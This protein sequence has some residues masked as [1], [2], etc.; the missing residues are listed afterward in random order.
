[1]P[2]SERSVSAYLC[3]DRNVYL[4]FDVRFRSRVKPDDSPSCALQ[5]GA[6]ADS[7]WLT[8]ALSRASAASRL[9]GSPCEAMP[10]V[11]ACDGGPDGWSPPR[12]I[13]GRDPLSAPV[14]ANATPRS[15]LRYPA[16]P[17]PPDSRPGREILRLTDRCRGGGIWSMGSASAQRAGARCA[18][19]MLSLRRSL[20]GEQGGWLSVS[21]G[22]VAWSPVVRPWTSRTPGVEA[23]QGS[24]GSDN[25][26]DADRPGERTRALA[27]VSGVPA[28]EP[29]FSMRNAYR[30]GPGRLTDHPY[31]TI[32][33]G[34]P[35]PEVVP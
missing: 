10:V 21:S 17:G 13:S 34:D 1:M 18:L 20:G 11:P 35:R 31:R 26:E 16:L 5:E 4:K 6:N 25:V 15:P 27:F 30:R 8:C 33:I 2:N 9:S 29:A 14:A 24:G 28:V 7:A 23:G 19:A 32:L 22:Q 3:N 12:M